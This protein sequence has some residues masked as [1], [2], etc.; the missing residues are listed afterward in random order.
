MRDSS[1]CDASSYELAV[2]I[3]LYC[4]NLKYKD[5]AS[6][7]AGQREALVLRLFNYHHSLNCW[8]RNKALD[9]SLLG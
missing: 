3:V 7:C 8:W 4:A 9:Y 6:C 5:S 1:L 2:G